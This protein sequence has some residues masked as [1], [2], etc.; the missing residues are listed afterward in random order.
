MDVFVYGTLTDPAR[1][2]EV[3]D[4][5]EYAGEATLSGLHRVDGTYPTLAPGGETRGRLLRT[6]ALATL[7]AYEGVDRGL[8]ARVRVP[9]DARSG[10]VWTYVGDPEA[11][12]APAEWPG[13]G[14]F[15]ERVRDFIQSRPVV[16]RTN[17]VR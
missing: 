7:D 12:F 1:A 15:P 4:D 9:S 10:S 8:Y 14:P 11:L 5:Y 2:D 17:D 13:D 16:V 6:S 3:L